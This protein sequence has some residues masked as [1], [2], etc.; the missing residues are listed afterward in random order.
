MRELK[1]GMINTQETTNLISFCMRSNLD[2]DSP[3]KIMPV[4]PMKIKHVYFCQCGHFA[5]TK[6]TN[7]QTVNVLLHI[8]ISNEVEGG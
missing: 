4:S 3:M 7:I 8:T 5:R 2:V 6:S 1:R